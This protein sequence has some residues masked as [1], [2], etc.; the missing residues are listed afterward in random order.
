MRC[1]RSNHLLGLP[2]RVLQLPQALLLAAGFTIGRRA[3]SD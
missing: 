1:D 2:H 3:Q